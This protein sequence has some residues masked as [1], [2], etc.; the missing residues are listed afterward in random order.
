MKNSTAYSVYT[1]S[2]KIDETIHEH[3]EIGAGVASGA[4]APWAVEDLAAEVFLGGEVGEVGGDA[5]VEL[6]L[7]G[8]HG[9]DEL[10]EC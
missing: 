4:A 8:E 7:V 1:P 10:C 2:H 3:D 6:R 5:P 9:A